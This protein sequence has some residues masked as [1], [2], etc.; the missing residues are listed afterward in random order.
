[1]KNTAKWVILNAMGVIFEVGDDTNDLLVPHIQ[2]RNMPPACYLGY[3]AISMLAA[4]STM[5]LRSRNPL[6]KLGQVPNGNN[7]RDRF[8]TTPVGSPEG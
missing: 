5:I 2:K 3:S 1:M 4:C 6:I 8:S 7:R